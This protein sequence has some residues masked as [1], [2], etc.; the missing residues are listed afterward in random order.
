MW[1]ATT[2]GAAFFRIAEH[3]NR[4]QFNALIG[5][6]PRIVVSDR[7]NG[8]SHLDPNQRR[9][10]WSHLRHDFRRHADGLGEQKTFGEHGFALTGQV[11]PP[12]APTGTSTTTATDS[13]PRS[14]RSRPSCGTC[15]KKPAPRAGATA[16]T[17]SSPTTCARSGRALDLHHHRRR[18][19]DHQPR[20]T[21]APRPGHPPRTLARHPK[22]RP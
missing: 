7:W 21:R 15:S 5:P 16:G 11:L 14:P 19:S 2:R 17:A 13:K 10:C 20:R 1:T 9:V 8:Y 4:E 3:C 22:P 18:R 6:Y 12:G